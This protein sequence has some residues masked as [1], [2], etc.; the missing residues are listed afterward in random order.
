EA[1]VEKM[2]SFVENLGLPTRLAALDLDLTAVD[3][4]IVAEETTRMVLIQNNLRPASVEECRA[5][6][7]EML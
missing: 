3:W 4:D 1:L 7:A 2:A 5:I 6:L